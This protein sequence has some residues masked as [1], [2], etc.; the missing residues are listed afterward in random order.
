MTTRIDPASAALVPRPF[1]RTGSLRCGFFMPDRSF[2]VKASSL[3]ATE[4]SGQVRHRGSSIA[5]LRR[6]IPA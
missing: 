5:E 4:E 1:S 3:S 6:R 2:P